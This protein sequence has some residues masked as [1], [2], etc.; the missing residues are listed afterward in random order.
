MGWGKNELDDF[1][2]WGGK[3]DLE[4]HLIENGYEVYTLSVG[5]VSSNWDRAIEAYY[6][7]KG[8]QVDYGKGHSEKYN[9]IQK[10]NKKNFDGLYPE[11][12][13]QNPVHIIG[14]SQGGQTARMLEY[15]LNNELPL[16]ESY[17]L[18]EKQ[19]NWIKSV[20]TISTP[21]NGTTIAP[22]IQNFFPNIQ[23]TII[24]LD[25]ISPKMYFDFDL[26]QWSLSR[27]ENESLINYIQRIK[28]SPIKDTK[29]FSYWDLS[30]EGS[31]HFNTL[32]QT[33]PKTFYFTFATTNN[34]QPKLRYSIQS[35]LMHNNKNFSR[36]WKENDG[37]VNTI[38]M[39][40]PENAK[41]KDFNGEPE[42][43]IWQ[44][45][46]KVYLDHNEIIG[47]NVNQAKLDV[48]KF[49][50]MNH[51]KLLYTLD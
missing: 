28:K 8:G 42:K 47:H 9:I 27:I 6:Q 30:V 45:I 13:E 17:L 33:D 15:I 37:L 39:I 2:Y 44:F 31:K 19:K 34:N 3:F 24:W 35:N 40:G 46:G 51:C 16:E 12:N 41:K 1:F 29:N 36:A 48:V 7:I 21:H 4:E 26:D 14:H 23:S 11:W 22:I 49:L 50:F 25:I 18:Q 32:Y 38:S 5:P 43:G 20:T 10:P